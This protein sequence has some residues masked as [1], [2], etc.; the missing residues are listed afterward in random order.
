MINMIFITV[1]P[2]L[3]RRIGGRGSPLEPLISD[4]YSGL[5]HAVQS[6]ILFS[7]Q[8]LK[9]LS[10]REVK[11]LIHQCI[12]VVSLTHASQSSFNVPPQF[13]FELNTALNQFPFSPDLCSEAAFYQTTTWRPNQAVT[14]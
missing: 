4:L 9:V 11:I 10:S 5:K 12:A 6:N 14:V 7:F 13:K 8:G 3:N 2:R 1:E